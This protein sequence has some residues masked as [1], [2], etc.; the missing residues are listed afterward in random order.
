MFDN[1]T[2]LNILLAA[3]QKKSPFLRQHGLL[4][5]LATRQRN[6]LRVAQN[7]Y[8]QIQKQRGFH[9]TEHHNST[10]EEIIG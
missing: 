1:E 7:V 2:G 4:A 8:Q 10:I 6:I 3:N 9:G 5:M